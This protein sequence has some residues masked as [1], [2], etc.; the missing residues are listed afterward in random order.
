MPDLQPHLIYPTHPTWGTIRVVCP[1]VEVGGCLIYTEGTF[2]DADTC[3]CTLAGNDC[4]NCGDGL[5]E[6]CEHLPDYIEGVGPSCRCEESDRCGVI[7]WLDDLHPSEMIDTGV[8]PE[9]YPWR[10]RVEWTDG[11]ILV[12]WTDDEQEES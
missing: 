8:W 10:A 7:E 3:R 2:P 4:P 1:G 11:P 6:L 12:P 9:L 5:H